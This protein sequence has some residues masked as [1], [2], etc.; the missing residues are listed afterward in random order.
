MSQNR[1]PTS[2]IRKSVQRI[3]GHIKSNSPGPT[4]IFFGGIH[5]NEP[6]GIR[7]LQQ[8]FL[9]L[10]TET[11]P[12]YGEFYGIAGNLS[13]L[14]KGVR[15]VDEDLNRI[16]LPHSMGSLSSLQ[17]YKTS[18][19]QE[20]EELDRLIREILRTASPPFYFIDLHTTSGETEPFIVMNDSLLNRRFT[21]NYPLPCILGIEE[22]LTGALLSH[23]NE[24]GYVAFGF[25]S[26]QHETTSAVTN[27]LR[28]IWYTL[29]LTGF[30]KMDNKILKALKAKLNSSNTPKRFFEIYHQHL[31][32]ENEAFKMLPGFVNFQTV[33]KGSNISI[34]FGKPIVTK[35]R[36]QLFMPLYQAKGYEGFY[37][38]RSVPYFFLWLSKHLRKLR[39]DGFLALLPGIKWATS[40]KDTL[41]VDK[42]VARFFA[43]S[44]FH[45][46][47]YRTRQMDE[48]HFVLKSRE[49]NSKA[50]DYK[51]APWY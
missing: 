36:R 28:F 14:A 12:R 13:A 10:E 19:G 43:K 22:Y 24:M 23:I 39:A 32:Q 18:E 16:W 30:H 5:G 51:Q 4:L 7:A 26:G 1:M 44:I 9:Q 33:P 25:E 45:L 41:Y 46:L 35:K 6:A 11:T 2:G 27:A 50:S 40:K 37:F 29:G 8:V 38:I 20:M 47:G 21:R 48:S 15:F 42:R 3:V 31:I 17:P 49:R 34:S